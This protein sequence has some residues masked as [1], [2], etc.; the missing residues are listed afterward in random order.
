L[1]QSGVL[2]LSLGDRGTYVINKQPPNKQIWL[3]SPKRYAV[4]H[5]SVRLHKCLTKYEAGQNDMTSTLNKTNG[6]TAGTTARCGRYWKR[7]SAMFSARR[8]RC[9]SAIARGL[10]QT[11]ILPSRAPLCSVVVSCRIKQHNK[12][13]D[14]LY[15]KMY[16][17]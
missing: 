11:H 16:N 13:G 9:E 6:F 10:G 17:T 7:N 2:T 15:A 14:E 3:S 4:R 1:S 5:T 8:S 12:I